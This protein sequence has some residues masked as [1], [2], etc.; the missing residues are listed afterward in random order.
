MTRLRDLDQAIDKILE[1]TMSPSPR[2]SSW[3]SMTVLRL[4][5]RHGQQA[6][7]HAQDQG[8]EEAQG[9][10]TRPTPWHFST[11]HS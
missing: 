9:Q 10:E 4:V 11:G 3:S 8:E 6:K 7:D 1:K 5:S 2:P